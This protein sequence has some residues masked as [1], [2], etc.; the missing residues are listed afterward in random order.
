MYS[1][2]SH[3]LE[4]CHRLEEKLTALGRSVADRLQL[5]A[6]IGAHA[7]PGVYGVLYVEA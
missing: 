3:G 6:A 4:N 5:G 1:L 2:Y 7:G